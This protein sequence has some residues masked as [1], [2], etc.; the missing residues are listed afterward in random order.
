M[1]VTRLTEMFGA[2]KEEIN[3]DPLQSLLFDSLVYFYE[4]MMADN[5][6][7]PK[8]LEHFVSDC[9]TYITRDRL[10]QINGL[11]E[12]ELNSLSD[13]EILQK[14]NDL[15]GQDQYYCNGIVQNR[16]Y[17]FNQQ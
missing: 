9:Y 12:A 14:Q 5:Q 8:E 17:I 1:I 7:I 4:S 13:E 10:I 2:K 15:S 11:I 3:S 6:N 16:K